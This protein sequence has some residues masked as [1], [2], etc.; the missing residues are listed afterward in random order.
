Y[1]VR[2]PAGAVLVDAGIDVT[3]GDMVAGLKALDLPVEAGTAILLSPW[4]H[5][6][7]PRAEGIPLLSRARGY[8]RR[9][10]AVHFTCGAVTGARAWVAD[11][12]PEFGLLGA[13][14]GILG[15]SPPRPVQATGYPAD[16]DLLEGEFEVLET[17]GHSPG[18]LSYFYRPERVLFSG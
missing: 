8:Y 16:G 17:P 12:V 9:K 3:G 2:T 7:S 5:D 15:E 1:V 14:K 18:H 11:R 6:H 13:L 4:P 10:E